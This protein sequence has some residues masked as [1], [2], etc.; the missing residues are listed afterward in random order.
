MNEMELR[1]KIS[2]YCE[3]T[4]CKNCK[5]DKEP[6]DPPWCM[7][8]NPNTLPLNRLKGITDT[9]DGVE[10]MEE[11]NEVEE[12][13]HDVIHHPNHYCREGGMESIEEMIL[14]FGKEA[15]KHFC[16]CNIWK[17]RYRSTHKNGE[18]D[19]KKSDEYMRIYARLCSNE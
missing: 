13:T 3:V 4:A 10:S 6:E 2:N 5:F 9:I 14:V 1:Q 11:V 15:V 16:L 8:Y 7:F 18:E 19:I 17:Y 12:V